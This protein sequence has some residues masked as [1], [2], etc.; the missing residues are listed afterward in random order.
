MRRVGQSLPT[1]LGTHSGAYWVSVCVVA[2]AAILGVTPRTLY[3]SV[4]QAVD[5]R[6]GP[7]SVQPHAAPQQRIVDQFFADLYMSAAEHLAAQDLDI[8]TVGDNIAHDAALPPGAAVP[9]EP[10]PDI[11]WNPD[12]CFSTQS[13]MAA[14][15]DLHNFP[16]RY[17]QHGRMSDLWWQFLAWWHSLADV[18]QEE[19]VPRPSLSTSWRTWHDLWHLVLQFRKSSYHGCCTQCFRYMQYL[20]KGQGSLASKQEAARNWRAHLRSQ[21]HGR[22]L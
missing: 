9:N 18:P 14:G 13:L 2:L 10:L 22:L 21:Y 11:P 1:K 6:K 8:G 19:Q 4:H 12:Q 7:W 5:L 17:L 16:V 20:H 15:H 3:K